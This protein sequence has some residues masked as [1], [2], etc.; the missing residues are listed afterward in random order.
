MKTAI[1]IPDPIFRSAEQ[2]ASR[3]RVSRSKLYCKA[4]Q[5]FLDEHSD[6]LVTSRLNEIY[7]PG[8]EGSSVD[9][10]LIAIQRRSVIRA[11][12]W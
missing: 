8:A 3:L 5:S 10:E 4:L 12:K 11:S 1:S 9:S 6:E 7:A 2:L